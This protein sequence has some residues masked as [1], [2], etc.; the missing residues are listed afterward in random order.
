MVLI[1]VFVFEDFPTN[2]AFISWCFKMHG[3]YMSLAIA[4]DG[5]ILSTQQTSP[6][7][8][9]IFRY[10]FYKDV[11]YITWN[12]TDNFIFL[13]FHSIFQN[14]SA[15]KKYMQFQ[16]FRRHEFDNKAYMVIFIYS[17]YLWDLLEWTLKLSL[18]LK[19]FP[20]KLHSSPGWSM[21]WA[22]TCLE[23]SPLSLYSLPHSRHLQ[24][25]LL[26]PPCSRVL[27]IFADI[28]SSR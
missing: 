19:S 26:L 27:V 6:S 5:K 21:W 20:H 11:I 15:L 8:F 3:L 1:T 4:L 22:S 25:L 2:L 23:V 28:R 24:T 14:Y 12:K 13:K 17:H 18:V 16:I 10:S 9:A 7:N